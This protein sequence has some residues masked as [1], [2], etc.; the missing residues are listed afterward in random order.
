MEQN[1]GETEI[2]TRTSAHLTPRWAVVEV[3]KWD[4]M[5]ATEHTNCRVYKGFP[6][7]H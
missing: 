4:R 6:S 2:E 7:A 3:E 5:W 1:N